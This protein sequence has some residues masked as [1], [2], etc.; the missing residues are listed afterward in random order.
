MRVL[1]SYNKNEGYMKHMFVIFSRFRKWTLMKTIGII[2]RKFKLLSCP[3]YIVLYII[4]F[5]VITHSFT[6]VYTHPYTRVYST[7]YIRGHEKEI[8]KKRVMWGWIN[9]VKTSPI[10]IIAWYIHCNGDGTMCVSEGPALPASLF[11]LLKS[12]TVK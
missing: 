8:N 11:P 1:N 10:L 12:C 6:H 7:I 2:F 5:Y 3:L 9:E 4:I